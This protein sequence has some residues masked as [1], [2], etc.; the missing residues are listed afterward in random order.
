MQVLPMQVP[1]HCAQAALAW[2]GHAR[3]QHLHGTRLCGPLSRGPVALRL[4]QCS[5]LSWG[6]RPRQQQRFP[7]RCAHA[8]E[9]RRGGSSLGLD[10]F[11]LGLAGSKGQPAEEG[12]LLRLEG[13]LI[14]SLATRAGVAAVGG[15]LPAHALA[16]MVR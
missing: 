5:P 6:G 15:L 13:H 4:C 14:C 1:P 9:Q 3:Q 12:V 7:T 11:Y 16:L 2:L 8:G 10:D